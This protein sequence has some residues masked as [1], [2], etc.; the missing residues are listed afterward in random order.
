MSQYEED[1]KIAETLEEINQPDEG[2]RDLVIGE[3]EL[4]Y[5]K[6]IQK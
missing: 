3:K 4:E 2:F 6:T 5:L 1:E